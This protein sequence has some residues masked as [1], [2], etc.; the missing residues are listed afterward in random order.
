MT[1]SIYV[2]RRAIEQGSVE[3]GSL[4]LR[5]AGLDLRIILRSR[6]TAGA[7]STWLG[8]VLS[9]HDHSGASS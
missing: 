1:E 3:T 9:G 8:Q 5:G 4:L 7:A 6:R 2:R